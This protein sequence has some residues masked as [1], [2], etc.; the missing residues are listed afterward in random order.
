MSA[1]LRYSSTIGTLN[2]N[3]APAPHS[4]GTISDFHTSGAFLMSA[5][6]LSLILSAGITVLALVLMFL[7]VVIDP[8]P[9]D[10]TELFFVETAAKVAVNGVRVFGGAFG[11][12][13]IPYVIRAVSSLVNEWRRGRDN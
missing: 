13:L 8:D 4:L 1:Q 2:T 10:L 5:I 9:D 12:S 6:K 7:W 3:L 11:V